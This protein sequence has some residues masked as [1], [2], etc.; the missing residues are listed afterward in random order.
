MG[1]N[2]DPEMRRAAVGKIGGGREIDSEADHH[3]LTLAFKQDSPRLGPVEKQIV[4]PF[5][6]QWKPWSGDVD[7]FDQRQSGGQ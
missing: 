7:R 1:R 6:E 5:Q 4:G 3:P 2:R